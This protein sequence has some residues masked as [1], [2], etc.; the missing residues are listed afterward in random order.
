[1]TPN[2]MNQQMEEDDDLGRGRV[3]ASLDEH[4][5]RSG[6]SRSTYYVLGKKFGAPKQF[7]IG[8]KIYVLNRHWNEWI[9]HIAKAQNGGEI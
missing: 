6:I 7:K 4:R 5:E 9:M 2:Y 8:R 3:E 1:M